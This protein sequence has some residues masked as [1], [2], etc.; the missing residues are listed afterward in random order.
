MEKENLDPLQSVHIIEQMISSV[1]QQVS[2]NGHLYLLWGWVVLVCSLLHFS[3]IYW[4]WWAEGHWVWLATWGAGLYQFFYMRRRKRAQRIATYSDEVLAGIWLVFV[5][6]SIV[7][8]IIIFQKAGWDTMYPLIMLLYGI[9][10]ILSGVVLRFR[11]LVVGGLIC[12][13][14]ALLAAFVPLLYNLI[15]TAAAVVAAWIV[16]GYMLNARYKLA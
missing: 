9:P 2:H 15:I 16:P 14:L 8:S 7:T 13:G 4:G 12:W 3:A 5:G 1:R 11:P 10:T 6:A